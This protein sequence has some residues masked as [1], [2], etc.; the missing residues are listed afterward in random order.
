MRRW[1]SAGLLLGQRRRRCVNSKPALGQRLMF[2]G[3]RKYCLISYY[4][5]L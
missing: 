5:M 3:W 2:A 4:D 1:P